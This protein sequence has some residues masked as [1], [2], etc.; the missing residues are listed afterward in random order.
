[1]GREWEW[2]GMGGGR[3]PTNVHSKAFTSDYSALGVMTHLWFLTELFLGKRL[4]TR[5]QSTDNQVG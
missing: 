4:A 2:V 3:W 1:M 5:A